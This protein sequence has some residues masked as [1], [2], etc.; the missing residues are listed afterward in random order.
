VRAESSLGGLLRAVPDAQTGVRESSAYGASHAARAGAIDSPKNSALD[1]HPQQ[2]DRLICSG[3]TNAVY[4]GLR[5]GQRCR[6]TRGN[7]LGFERVVLKRRIRD[8]KD[9]AAPIVEQRPVVEFDCGL[10]AL[11]D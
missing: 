9:T 11:L 4:M 2:S 10:L 1:A 6:A 5:T 7:L 3:Q 8:R